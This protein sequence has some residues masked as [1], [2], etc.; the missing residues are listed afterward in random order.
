MLGRASAI[1]LLAT[2]ISCAWDARPGP[3]VVEAR[4]HLER[5]EALWRR[6]QPAAYTLTV[7]HSIEL[8]I[9]AYGCPQQSF[10]VEDGQARFVPTAECSPEQAR[11]DVLGTVPALFRLIRRELRGRDDVSLSF[12]P[13]VGYP[14]ALYAGTRGMDDGFFAFEVL[15]FELK[16]EGRR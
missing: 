14:L 16:G 1:L 15:R 3:A 12:D 7:R 4:A 6:A 2:S 5:A 9:A 10:E 13:D 11:P 8:A